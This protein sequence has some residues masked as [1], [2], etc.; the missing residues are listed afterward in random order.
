MIKIS[1]YIVIIL[2]FSYCV[3]HLIRFKYYNKN[4]DMKDT[5]IILS[6]IAIFSFIYLLFSLVALLIENNTMSEWRKNLSNIIEIYNK[7][8]I[9]VNDTIKNILIL[10]NITAEEKLIYIRNII[11]DNTISYKS[12]FL[13]LLDNEAI[14]NKDKV[15][16]LQILFFIYTKENKID[17]TK[18][19]FN[20]KIVFYILDILYNEK[21]NELLYLNFYNSYQEIIE[22]T[23]WIWYE[24][25][26]INDEFLLILKSD[27]NYSNKIEILYK[28]FQK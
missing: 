26:I 21:K 28:M 25:V 16:F 17:Y 7:W 1:S 12:D 14:S 23:L 27:I 3:Y 9:N 10:N 19:K 11:Y 18:Y 22:K 15:V 24:S 2:I 8:Y 5:M 4:K 13:L 20:E 6:M